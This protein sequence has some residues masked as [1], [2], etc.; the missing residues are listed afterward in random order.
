MEK[1]NLRV[2]TLIKPRSKVSLRFAEKVYKRLNRRVLNLRRKAYKVSKSYKLRQFLDQGVVGNSSFSKYTF[3]TKTSKHIPTFPR[4][5][6][7]V[8]RYRFIRRKFARFLRR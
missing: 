6:T 3:P 2:N 1:K 7:R 4:R 5:F 8:K